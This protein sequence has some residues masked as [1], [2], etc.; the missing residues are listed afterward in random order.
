MRVLNF[1]STLPGRGAAVRPTRG[2]FSLRSFSIHA[3]REGSGNGASTARARPYVFYPRSPG[4]ERRKRVCTRLH[5]RVFYPRSPG[6]ERPANCFAQSG[7]KIIFY[8]RSPGGERPRSRRQPYPTS[9]FSI[10]APRE[11]S[12]YRHGAGRREVKAFLSTLPGRGAAAEVEA[13]AFIH[14]SFL[15]TLPGRGAAQVIH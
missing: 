15:S 5:Q 11:G 13:H 1:L 2:G 4:G 14:L 8:P 3:P 7:A 12:G 9:P 10:H 6:G